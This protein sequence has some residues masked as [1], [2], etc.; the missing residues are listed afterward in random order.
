MAD[1]IY[2]I[3]GADFHKLQ[4]LADWLHAGSDTARD[5]GHKLWLLLD[6][7]TEMDASDLAAQ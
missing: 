3:D 6:R 5:E 2:V 7:A 1:K 4:A